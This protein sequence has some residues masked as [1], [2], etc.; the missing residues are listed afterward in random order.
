MGKPRRRENHAE[1]K[2][3]QKGNQEEE[4]IVHMGKSGRWE[5]LTE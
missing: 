1:G 4:I 2:T 5:K 3:K